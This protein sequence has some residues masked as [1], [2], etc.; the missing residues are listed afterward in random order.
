VPALLS[1]KHRRREV[2]DANS[3]QELISSVPEGCDLLIVDQYTWNAAIERQCRPWAK[4]IAVIDDL[5]DRSHDCDILLD[6]TYGRNAQDY[7]GLVPNGAAIIVGSDYALLRP[8]F[9]AARS[10]AI[11]RRRSAKLARVLI[12]VGLTDPANSTSIVM[13]GIIES[14]LPIQGDVALGESSP[15]IDAVRDKARRY[16]GLFSL[17]TNSSRMAELMTCADFSFGAAGSTSWERCSLGLPTA[18]VIAAANQEKSAEN[19]TGA[20][21]G[22]NLGAS[23]TL[24]ASMIASVLRNLSK[25]PD[26]LVRMAESAWKIC[27]GRGAARVAARLIPEFSSSG[28]VVSLRSAGLKDVALIFEWQIE[29]GARK[30]SR[31]PASPTWQEHER[32]MR[33]RLDDP[34][35]LMN[36]IL[37][38]DQP[39]GVIRLDE[40]DIDSFE[41][42]ILVSRHYH[43]RGIGT[44]AVK[45]ARRLAPFSSIHAEVH[46]ENGGS[47][48]IFKAAGYSQVAVDRYIAAGRKP[49]NMDSLDV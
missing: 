47:H 13:D 22:I 24:T 11:K 26:E 33:L 3:A 48:R 43:G 29:P 1:S 14:G 41:L 10:L 16:P 27:D 30:Y 49:K 18:F 15:H 44:A 36:I 46:P 39:V 45:L 19:L 17:H 21:A 7:S 38:N 37:L 35:C 20:G 6:Q 5:A 9:A 32:W 28:D 2:A 23:S 42:S 8:E 31:N 40:I 34:G 12:A 4:R 25:A